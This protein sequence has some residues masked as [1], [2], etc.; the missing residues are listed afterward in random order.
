ML[1]QAKSFASLA[2]T[3]FEAVKQFYASKVGLTIVEEITGYMVMFKT[4]DG[5]LMLY[6]KSDHQPANNTVFN[7]EVENLLT[8]IEDLKTR[9]IN[10]EI[11][12]GLK[13]D[14]L[15]ISNEGPSPM[16]W[17]RDPAGNIIGLIQQ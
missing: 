12:P 2:A 9:G 5:K 11:Y 15:G 1:T 7:F 8:T 3:D 6:A 4:G 10:M 13:Q 14:E 16:A 17:F